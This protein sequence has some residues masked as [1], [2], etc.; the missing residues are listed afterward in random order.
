MLNEE[1]A[2][3]IKRKLLTPIKVASILTYGAL[4]VGAALILI[5]IGLVFLLKKN[6]NKTV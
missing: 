6:N 2:E 1:N 4:T 5:A 3:M